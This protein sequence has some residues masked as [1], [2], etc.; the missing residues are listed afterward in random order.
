[1]IRRFPLLFTVIA[2]LAA[3]SCVS[4]GSDA[5]FSCPDGFQHSVAY[6]LFFGLD[7]ADGRSVSQDEW[8][9]FLADTI[10]PR[11][12]WGLSVIDVTGQWQKP[13]GELERENTKLVMLNHPPP[14]A[15]GLT[16][17]DE[18]SQEYERRFNQDPVYREIFENM[19]N[20]LYIGQ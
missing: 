10:T 6:R 19:C 4:G 20:G 17:I 3:V 13:N 18:I 16:L 8:D 2:L 1:M 12:P 15:D 14:L 11:F 7:H 9:A 5:E